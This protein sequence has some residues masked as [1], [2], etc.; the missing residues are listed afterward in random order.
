M[1]VNGIQGEGEESKEGWGETRG[2]K[3]PEEG[4]YRTQETLR[5]EWV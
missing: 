1:D 5:T 4:T 2:Q 3:T